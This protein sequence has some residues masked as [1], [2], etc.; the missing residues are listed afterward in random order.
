MEEIE[1]LFKNNCTFV[2]YSMHGR[3][4]VSVILF[5]GF[6]QLTVNFIGGNFNGF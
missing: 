6:P 4:R 1:K 2:H 5:S 3:L